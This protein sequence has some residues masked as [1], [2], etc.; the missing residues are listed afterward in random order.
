MRE[1]SQNEAGLLEAGCEIREGVVI[2]QETV[3]D[4][5]ALA[6]LRKNPRT[7]GE[8]DRVISNNSQ[9][10]SLRAVVFFPFP[11]GG[12]FWETG[13]DIYTWHSDLYHEVEERG[14]KV[15]QMVSGEIFEIDGKR[16]LKFDKEPSDFLCNEDFQELTSSDYIVLTP[17]FTRYSSM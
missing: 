2:S 9:L 4:I 7:W 5:L 11:Q 6:R 13:T 10:S 12:S 3:R 8:M 14:I 16:F 17:E 1:R 15:T